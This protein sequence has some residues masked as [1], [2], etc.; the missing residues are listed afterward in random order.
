VRSENKARRL[1]G[2]LPVELVPGDMTDVSAF[3]GAL[4]GVQVVFHTAAYFREYYQPGEHWE[5]MKRINVDA[6]LRLLEAAEARGVARSVFTSSTG[7]L[8]TEEGRAADE[9][10]PYSDF[11]ETNPY[12]KTKVLAEQAIYRFLENSRMDLVLI[13]PG[14]MMGPGDAAPTSAGQL[15]LDL[16]DRKIPALIDGGSC[17]A[18]ARD[19]AA[20]MIAAAE[21][22]GRG[23]RYVV[24]GPL[25]TIED[26]ARD[27]E[28]ITGI[29]AP[30]LRMP[31]WLAVA[32]G[33]LTEAWAGLTG[34]IKTMSEKAVVSSAKAE[35]V[36][37]ARFR[38]R[39]DTVNDTVQWYR[40]HGYLAK[41][42][43]SAE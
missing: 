7:V 3:A 32:G 8:Q 29:K 20:A 42:G 5:T 24:T 11:T 6:T 18:D 22:G 1:L 43:F 33:G 19:V 16:L 25:A 26:I 39:R 10:A 38:P 17:L 4:D 35:R 40:E 14:W 34:G 21:R 9:T 2:G 31:A 30:R 27:L 41:L 36:L 13:L 37:G 23:E 28:E 15:I 12:F